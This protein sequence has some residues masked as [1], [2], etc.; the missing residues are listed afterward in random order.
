MRSYHHPAPEDIRLHDVL[1]AL[2]DPT[3]SRLVG[4]LRERGEHTVGGLAEHAG[5]I[6]KSTMSYHNKTLRE[7]GVTRIR[8]EGTRC[9]VSLRSEDLEARYPGLLDLLLA[10]AANEA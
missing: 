1:F 7:A 2:S 9:F 3:R 8:S 5:A 10:Y 6:P 4:L